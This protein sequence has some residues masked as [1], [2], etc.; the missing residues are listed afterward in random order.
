MHT[1]IYIFEYDWFICLGHNKVIDTLVE[2]NVDI[3]MKD[4]SGKTALH[5][6]IE[7]GKFVAFIE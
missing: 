7:T 6:A 3:N 2:C 1:E 4:K 5:V